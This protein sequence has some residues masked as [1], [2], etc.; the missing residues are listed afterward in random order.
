MLKRIFHR[1]HIYLTLISLVLMWTFGQVVKNL[2]FFNPMSRAVKNFSLSDIYYQMMNEAGYSNPSDI[3]TIIDATSLYDRSKIGDMMLQVSSLE[4]AVVGV[5]CIYE[6]FRGDTIGTNRLAEGLFSLPN[7]VVAFK[8]TNYDQTLGEFTSQRHS[9]FA[10]MEG[11]G[12]GY[13]NITY[14]AGG[15]TVR[16]LQTQ[17]VVGSDTLYSLPYQIGCAYTDDVKDMASSRQYMIDYT[18]TDFPVVHCDS[19]MEHPDLIRGR[20]VIIGATH[21]DADMHSSPYGRIPGT[22]IQAYILQTLLEHEPVKEVPPVWTLLISLFFIWL[23]DVMQT[24]MSY[25]G[26]RQKRP[27]V[28]LMLTT[29][30]TK[31]IIN[32]IWINI[33]VYINFL[34][35]N[36]G[37]IYFNP[38]TMLWCIALL[39]EAR[40][41]YNSARATYM[42]AKVNRQRKKPKNA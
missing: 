18:P 26:Q 22:V 13:S 35:F 7:P 4:P 31:N 21:D 24:E 15:I 14:D 9:F 27:F 33:L 16:S 42:A 28:K 2:S 1:N 38:S 20:I 41:F 32:F 29:A 3:I 5:D 11:I 39:V 6:G 17:R 37:D 30:F 8:L 34:V 10:P 19:I 12:E 40:L 25:F 36:I 23:T